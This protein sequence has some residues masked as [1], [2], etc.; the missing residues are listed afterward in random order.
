MKYIAYEL[1]KLVGIKYIRIIFAILLLLNGIF[2]LYHVSES[3]NG[4]P[5]VNAIQKIFSDY[6]I[7]PDSVEIEYHSRMNWEAEQNELFIENMRQGNYD[8]TIQ[9]LPNKYAP[10][11][12]TDTQVYS[13]VFDRIEYIKKYP[14]EIQKVIDRAI[15]NLSEYDLLDATNISFL[16]NYQNEVIEVY[17]GA[18]NNV[19]IGFEYTRGWDD[20]FTYNIVDIFIFLMIITIGTAIF[21][22]EKV[23]GFLPLLRISKNGRLKTALAKISAAIIVTCIIV[24][25]FSIESW[26]MVWFTVGYSNP[27]NAIQSF[28]IFLYC[29]YMITVG[30]Y[31]FISLAFKLLTFILIV[32]IILLCSVF[33]YNY[34]FTFMIGLCLLGIGIFT[35]ITNIPIKI[36]DFISVSTPTP[37]FERYRAFD[38]CNKVVGYNEFIF[39]LF[40]L[41]TVILLISTILKYA[42]GSTINNI[43]IVNQSYVKNKNIFNKPLFVHKKRN[44]TLSLFNIEA[45]KTVI[46]SHMWI[47]LILFFVLKCF[48]NMNIYYP[49]LSFSDHV[50]KEYMDMLSG[51]ITEDK[52]QYLMNERNMIDTI[53]EQKDE[54]MQLYVN[55]KIS[56]DEY[57]SYLTKYNYAYGRNEI[58]Q[59]IENHATYID[60]MEKEE[61]DAWFIYDTGWKKIF[62]A[63]IDWTLYFMFLSVFTNIF[64]KEINKKS[65]S[66]SFFQIMSVSKNGRNKT[67]LSKYLSSCT[68]CIIVSVIWYFIDII[69]VYLSYELPLITAPIQSIEFMGDFALNITIGQYIG[70]FFMIKILAGLVF[71]TILCSISALLCKPISIILTMFIIAFFPTLLSGFDVDVLHKIDFTS[72]ACATPLL[73]QNQ[74]TLYYIILCLSVCAILISCVKNKWNYTDI[75]RRFL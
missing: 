68:I 4:K 20:Y 13:E 32:S 55:D 40:S 52:R 51:E 44:Y 18:K 67:L 8:Y 30:E 72:F 45:Y 1:R 60:Y 6:S 37:L 36:L 38:I 59:I 29:P 15:A 28:D 43:N 42:V 19:K 56:F 58:F 48:L 49:N 73:L 10:E 70:I 46:S 26:I 2:C 74:T 34:I 3:N 7:S 16:K 57:Q 5:P 14:S 27:M 21:I 69:S 63:D 61:K 9:T 33:S 22:E 35:H 75:G 53:I 62:M 11:G 66:G 39:I 64:S 71:T 47:V 65:S 31:F 23:S 54:M 25:L 24:I 17:D 41:F 50:Y 12:F